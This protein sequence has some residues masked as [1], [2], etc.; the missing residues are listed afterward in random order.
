MVSSFF[1]GM[2]NNREPFE[3]RSYLALSVELWNTKRK[4]P[5]SICLL[6]IVFHL[7]MELNCKRY[8]LL[9]NSTNR[10]VIVIISQSEIPR[11]TGFKPTVLM[12]EIDKELP[13]K[14]NVIERSL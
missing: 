7:D 8:N 5:F 12:A 6:R 13:I 11:S 4:I 3:Y 9:Y 1:R 10:V 2:Y 14:N